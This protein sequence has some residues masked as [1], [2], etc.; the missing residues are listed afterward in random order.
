MAFRT[1][2]RGGVARLLV[3]LA[4]AGP[5]VQGLSA[6]AEVLWS[7]NKIHQTLYP[8]AQTSVTE[9]FESAVPLEHVYLSLPTKEQAWVK[10]E[11]SVFQRIIPGKSYSFTISFNASGMMSGSTTAAHL[12]FWVKDPVEGA[13]ALS[14]ALPLALRVDS[15]VKQDFSSITSVLESE[16]LP[17]SLDPLL[18]RFDPSQRQRAEEVIVK[19]SVSS[20]KRQAAFFKGARLSYGT[21]DIQ[22]YKGPWTEPDGRQ[23][24]VEFALTRQGD[25]EW[26]IINW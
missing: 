13:H 19:L 2:P 7:V 6:G 8:G 22:V 3:L 14:N 11:P 15:K 20:R 24:E 9:S 10:V 21:D 18:S 5:F 1:W 25:G 23:I 26:R 16:S 4:M 17:T 12:E